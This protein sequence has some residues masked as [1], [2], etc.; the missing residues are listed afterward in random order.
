M[1]LIIYDYKASSNGIISTLKVYKS[2]YFE[3]NNTEYTKVL[4]EKFTFFM[5]KDQWALALTIL[6][7]FFSERLF[8][9]IVR[10]LNYKF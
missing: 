8:Y 4:V 9:Q 6:W 5:L 3:D 10:S 7:L 1:H 2:N